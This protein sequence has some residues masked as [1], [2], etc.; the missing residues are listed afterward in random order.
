MWVGTSRYPYGYGPIFYDNGQEWKMLVE[1]KLISNLTYTI[2][3]TNR[4]VF[5]GTLNGIGIY[6]DDT[7]KVVFY[8]QANSSLQLYKVRTLAVDANGHLWMGTETQGSGMLK[9]EN[10]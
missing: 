5:F 7:E 9:K 2:C 1:P 8:N 6:S 10:L 4:R 3:S